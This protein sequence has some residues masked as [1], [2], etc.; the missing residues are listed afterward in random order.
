MTT[1]FEYSILSNPKDTQQLQAILDQCFNSLP[2]SSETYFNRIDLANFRIIHQAGQVAGGLATIHMGQW[3]GGQPVPMV[4][5]AAVGVAPEYRGAGAALSLMQQTLKE[6]HANQVP[7]SALYPATQRLYRQVGYE[8]GGTLCSWETPTESIQMRERSVSFERLLP[9]KHEVLHALYQQQASLTNGNLDRNQA[10]WQ[11][12][13]QSDDKETVYAYLLGSADQPE[14]YIVFSQHQIENSS[15][16][17]V[18]D[19]ALLT[20]TAVRSFW[21]FVA[22][23]RSQMKKVRWRGPAIDALTLS[24]PEQVATIRSA[25]RWMLRIVDVSRAL[26]KRG[27]PQN[28]QAELHLDVYDHLLPENTSKFILSVANG[29]GEVTRGGKGELQ[30]DIRGLAPLY[31]GLFTPHQLQLAGQLTAPEATLATASQLFVGTSPWML[32]FF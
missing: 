10:I 7:I 25:Q 21:T 23:H 20:S 17:W 15:I 32:D 6:F 18:R 27:Y 29:Y 2:G 24:L 16:L 26:E 3:F 5:I 14:G 19:W 1:H 12:V 28:I 11:G 4:G 31:T 22:D 8:Q 9:V 30:I 13:T